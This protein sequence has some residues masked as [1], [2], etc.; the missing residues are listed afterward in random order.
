MA[1]C[2]IQIIMNSSEYIQEEEKPRGRGKNK[3]YYAGR[4]NEFV[5]HR[6]HIVEQ[7][8]VVESAQKGNPYT[9][10]AY[11]K[12]RL[13]TNAIAKSNRPTG[14]LFT[15]EN[16]CKVMGANKTG[17]ML[18]R[19]SSQSV[20]KVKGTVC[21]AEEIVEECLNKKTQTM[22]LKPS[23]ERSEVGAI[24]DVLLMTAEDRCG[25][26]AEEIAGF[27]SEHGQGYLYVELFETIE[28]S[29]LLDGNDAYE[30]RRMFAS[31]EEGLRKI[32]GI[33]VFRCNM[34][35]AQKSYVVYMTGEKDSYVQLG[36][37]IV[38]SKAPVLK[39]SAN[40]KDYDQLLD[41]LTTHPVVRR[42]TMSPIVQ[43][44]PKPS[45]R[46]NNTQKASIP[47]SGDMGKYPLIG[48]ADTGIADILEDWVVARV[49]NIN[50]RFK[51]ASHGTFISG[52]YVTGKVLNPS[53]MKERDGNRL[54]EICVL[55]E[56]HSF[57]KAYP[58]GLDEFLMNLE[59]SIVEAVESTG[60]RII[61][62]SMN[63]N[64]ARLEEEYSPFAKELD[65]I[66]IEN[67][68]ILVISAGNLMVTHRDWDEKDEDVNIAEFTSR[69]D[70]I[71]YAPAESV[72]NISVGALN[73]PDSLGLTNYTCIG[74]GLAT[75]T[76]PDLVHVGG[77]GFDLP[78]VG[79]GLYSINQEGNITTDCGTSFAAP[80]VAKTIAALDYMTE[81]GLPRE[82][83]IALTIHN[84]VV[85]DPFQKKKYKQFLKDWIGFGMSI[86]A[87]TILNGDEHSISLVFHQ[88][89]RKGQVYKF[90]FSWP[91]SLIKG[92]RCCGHVKVT[93]VSTPRLDYDYNAELV[94]EEITV[95]LHQ[96]DQ[97]G[98]SLGSK[99]KPLYHVA[100]G[101]EET[102]ARYEDELI[103]GYYKW[104]P[105]KVYDADFK[106]GYKADDGPWVL[107]ARYLERDNSPQ[108]EHGVGFTIILTISDLK[109]EAPVYNEMR[110]NLQMAGVQITDIQNAVRVQPRA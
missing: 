32:A 108:G 25:L 87:E 39:A 35:T 64:V 82:T 55:P 110:Q 14:K 94:R 29:D 104:N 95:S 75:G 17:E 36:E 26:S 51:D 6:E 40:A 8:D 97:E 99:L 1:N 38:G 103:E 52:L 31:F 89:I 21:K 18:V 67:D 11:A 81:R 96:V 62:L 46:Y 88:A 65:R 20:G 71:V 100:K 23:R 85:P 101:K 7:L 12:I 47:K 91:T 61:G 13:E 102:V 44:V 83:L 56:E 28:S 45:F 60:V 48:V 69:K 27:V 90:P 57:Y 43:S 105:V 16:D 93:M 53:F 58:K 19:F 59:Y 24:R 41:F 15:S 37:S 74:K 4:D 79:T 9:Q 78:T 10:I 42:V 92:G 2:P 30:A 66:A 98:K 5:A 33:R 54:V 76:K 107:E 106:R 63:M 73:P 70:D 68:V 77:F 50:P 109:Y 22:E 34:S 3:D 49:D 80:M 72:R 86:D 84:A